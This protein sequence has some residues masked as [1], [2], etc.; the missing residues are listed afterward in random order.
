MRVCPP[1]PTKKTISRGRTPRAIPAN[2]EVGQNVTNAAAG[3]GKKGGG[4]ASTSAPPPP[5]PPQSGSR[6]SC[7][8]DDD[9]VQSGVIDVDSQ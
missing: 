5:P 4:G 7:K 6:G 8:V 3:K 2:S 1:P 9:L